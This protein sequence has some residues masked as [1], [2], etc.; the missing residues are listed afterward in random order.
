MKGSLTPHEETVGSLVAP[1]RAITEALAPRPVIVGMTAEHPPAKPG[2]SSTL[3][4]VCL[5]DGTTEHL[6]M[7]PSLTDE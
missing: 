4:G 5:N 2:R 7:C 3:V 6:S 1:R